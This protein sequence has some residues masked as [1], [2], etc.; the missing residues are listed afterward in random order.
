MYVGIR[1]DRDLTDTSSSVS[2]LNAQLKQSQQQVDELRCA[3]SELKRTNSQHAVK[4][5]DLKSDVEHFKSTS[6]FC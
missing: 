5:A 6:G 1:Q 3:E 2:E 4:I